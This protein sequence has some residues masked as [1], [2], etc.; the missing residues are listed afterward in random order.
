MN[1]IEKMKQEYEFLIRE[2]QMYENQIDAGIKKPIY[3][4]VQKNGIRYYSFKSGN[5][6]FIG[7]HNSPEVKAIQHNRFCKEKVKIL[8][9]NIAALTKCMEKFSCY[10]QEAVNNV[11]PAAYRMP[12]TVPNATVRSKKSAKNSQNSLFFPTKNISITVDGSKVK[13][14]GEALIYNLLLH[15]DVDFEYEKRL[16]LLDENGVQVQFYPDFTIFNDNDEIYWEH[17]GM[18]DDPNYLERQMHKIRIFQNNGITIGDR[19]IVTSDRYD[20]SINTEAIGNIIKAV[21]LAQ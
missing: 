2:L 21:L 5:T 7:D 11:L 8:K 17:F 6:I 12:Q 1:F 14:K 3:C 4:K 13:S 10:T 15:Y 16:L 9:K 19:L 20:R 18:L